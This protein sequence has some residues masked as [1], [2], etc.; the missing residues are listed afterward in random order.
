MITLAPAIIAAAFMSIAPPPEAPSLPRQT[1]K[2]VWDENT[3]ALV[4]KLA[5]FGTR[6]T[7]SAAD[8]AGI[9]SGRGIGAARAWI[10]ATLE[11]Y[12]RGEGMGNADK[13]G[14]AAPVEPRLTV[15]FESFEAP[16]STRLPEGG[17]LVNI[18]AMLPGTMAGGAGDA[19]KRRVYIVGHYDSR[20]AD[21][22]DVKGDAPGANDDASGVAAA[23]EAARV[24]AGVKLDT[25]VVFLL[26]AGEEQGL[27]GAQYHAAQAAARGEKITAVLNNDIVGDPRDHKGTG[28]SYSLRVFSEGLPRNPTAEQLAKIR[29][30]SGESDSPSRQLARFVEE[31]GSLYEGQVVTTA[32]VFRQ[33]RFLRGGDHIAFNDNGFPAVRFTTMRENYDRQHANVTTKDGAPYGDIARYIDSTYLGRVTRLNVAAAIHLANAPSTPANVRIVTAE[34][35]NPTTIRWEASPESDVAGYEV[36]YRNT[37]EPMWTGGEVV[38]VGNVTEI[39]LDKNKDDL[40]FG[41]RAYDREGY[42]SVVG[43]AGA[44]KE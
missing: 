10:K 42:R 1:I 23:M 25:T 8:E 33:D 22:M 44:A 21:A 36:V 14:D 37:I 30:T 40:F 27:L 13:A 15:A 35:G 7:L 43:F 32:L 2:K 31:I 24:L 19:A 18:V 38:D 29:A 4:E 9:A 6:H 26:T 20:N 11:Q 39:T 16:K 17:T 41:V 34:L 5:G 28:R 3:L 12:A